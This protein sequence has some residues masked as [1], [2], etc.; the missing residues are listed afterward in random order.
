MKKLKQDNIDKANEEKVV[1]E[2][3]EKENLE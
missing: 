3:A 1:L 2:K